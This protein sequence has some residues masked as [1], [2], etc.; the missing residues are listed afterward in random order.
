MNSAADE[1]MN[2]I[3]GRWRSQ[4]L[5]AG[6][7]LGV[8]EHLD[9]VRAKNAETI[10]LELKVDPALLYRLL[11]A[12]A[13]IGLLLEDDTRGFVLTDRGYLLRADPS[14]YLTPRA[15]V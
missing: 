1:V 14:Q 5:S 3:F 7:E 10:A 4:T 12:Q 6:T 9:R 15:R 11:R 13:A 2:L 8:F